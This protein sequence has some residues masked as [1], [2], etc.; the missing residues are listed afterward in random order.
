MASPGNAR[1]RLDTPLD[2]ARLEERGVRVVDQTTSTNEDVAALARRGASPGLVIVTEHQTAGRG[3]L[4]RPWETPARTALTFSLLLRPAVPASAWPWLPLL[5]GLAVTDVLTAA[6]FPAR[7]KWP[8]DVMIDDRKVAGILLEL[9][10]GGVGGPAAVA[11][12]GLNVRLPADLL[13]TETA[14]SLLVEAQR[15]GLGVPR[16]TDLL[17]DVLDALGSRLERWEA[18]GGAVQTLREAYLP[19]CVTIGRRV[20]VTLPVGDPLVGVAADI[21]ESGRLVVH[22][23]AVGPG[24]VEPV[25]VAAGD[26]VHVRPAPEGS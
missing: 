6:G 15:A 9:V 22:P 1:P 2:R 4:A 13:P 3:R 26:V 5:T 20:R 7:L 23:D 19:V 11:G 17:L 25:A 10:D 12:I 8:N 16:R 21:D 14:T 24:D 18:A